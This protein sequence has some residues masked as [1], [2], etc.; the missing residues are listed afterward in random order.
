MIV[1]LKRFPIR[2]I[3]VD[4][5]TGTARFAA[6]TDDR[7]AGGACPVSECAAGSREVPE[8]DLTFG[9]PLEAGLADV[10]RRLR[11][12]WLAG[13]ALL[14]GDVHSQG[15]VARDDFEQRVSATLREGFFNFSQLLSGLEV[16]LLQ[17]QQLGVVSEQSMLGIEQLVV[18]RGNGRCQN[19]GV[20][21][22]DG[23]LADLNCGGD[24]TDCATDERKVHEGLPKEGSEGVGTL[25]S[26]A[27]DAPHPISISNHA[28]SPDKSGDQ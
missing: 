19:V 3:V 24:G 22:S 23:C 20:S 26:M 7:L 27:G 17:R 21:H 2:R 14:W 9:G 10:V 13:P 16:L 5:A 15:E 12:T 1:S 6:I 4:E 11:S 18:H 28:S 8:D 25:D